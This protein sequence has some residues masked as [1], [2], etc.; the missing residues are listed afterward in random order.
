MTSG[1]VWFFAKIQNDRLPVEPPHD[2]GWRVVSVRLRA[3]GDLCRILD[4]PV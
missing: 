3:I 4:K 2:L 1:D